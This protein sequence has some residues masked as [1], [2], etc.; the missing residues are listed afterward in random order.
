[1][2]IAEVVCPAQV[3]D[4][5]QRL[6]RVSSREVEE[7]FLNFPEFRRGPRSK[8]AG[9]YLY[10]ALGQTDAGRYLFVVFNYERRNR[11]VLIV[12][13]REMNEREKRGYKKRYG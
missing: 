5:I 11:R 4:K 1:M 10:Y 6:H 2:E 3:E 9:E 13:A 12:T 7:V 8:R